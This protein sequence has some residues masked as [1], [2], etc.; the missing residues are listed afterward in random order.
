MLSNMF[1][2]KFLALIT[3]TI[4][5]LNYDN[6]YINA[7]KSNEES[8]LLK[9]GK[10]KKSWTPEELVGRCFGLKEAHKIDEYKTFNITTASSCRAL[11]C[12]I[13]KILLG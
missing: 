4:L 13:G 6:L 9:P 5:L 2:I 7:S 11:C 8:I 12:N 3:I 10:C 1:S